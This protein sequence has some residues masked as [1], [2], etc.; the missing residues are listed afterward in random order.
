MTAQE[1][2]LQYRK[3]SLCPHL[4]SPALFLT[5]SCPTFS[6]WSAQGE[7]P[8]RTMLSEH[9]N[10]TTST[11]AHTYIYTHD[12]DSIAHSLVAHH[13]ATKGM[14]LDW[15]S[16]TQPSPPHTHMYLQLADMELVP[17]NPPLQLFHSVLPLHRKKAKATMKHTQVSH[18]RP[19]K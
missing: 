4:G 11:H 12:C 3:L 5:Y 8:T 6:L 16:I 10:N 9:F 7:T 14:A 19:N 17:V 15:P 13:T 18:N 2:S 1:N